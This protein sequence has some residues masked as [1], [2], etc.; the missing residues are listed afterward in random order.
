MKRSIVVWYTVVRHAL[1]ICG[2]KP[3]PFHLMSLPSEY[4]AKLPAAGNFSLKQRVKISKLVNFTIKVKGKKHC[5]FC[6]QYV[7][8]N[9]NIVNYKNSE[10]KIQQ[11]DKVP[12]LNL[13]GSWDAYQKI[14]LSSTT[15]WSSVMKIILRLVSFVG[16]TMGSTIGWAQI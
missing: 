12:S 10:T 8:S 4:K 5:P 1:W 3:C 2:G 15:S 11:T 13:S 9:N 6:L 14:Y 7:P 16:V